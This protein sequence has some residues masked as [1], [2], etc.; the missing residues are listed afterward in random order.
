MRPTLLPRSAAA[1]FVVAM[2]AL[3]VLY[4]LATTSA[5]FQGGLLPGHLEMNARAAAALLGLLSVEAAASGNLV[6]LAGFRLEVVRG[7]DALDA[8]AF[9]SAAVVAF[10]AP[11]LRK[12]AGV[13]AGFAAL[14]AINVV[15]IA[16]LCVVGSWRPDLFR[17][18]HVE[19]GQ[20]SFVLCAFLLWVAW[21]RW[22]ASPRTVPRPA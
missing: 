22:A 14:L 4:G 13:A 21:A 8:G 5:F 16:L 9:F 20:V 7:C 10:P 3:V 15:R 19:V 17:V 18:V 2:G 12:A 11:L 6:G 1:R